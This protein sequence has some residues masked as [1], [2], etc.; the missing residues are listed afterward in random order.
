MECARGCPGTG[1][2]VRGRVLLEPELLGTERVLAG[3]GIADGG[4]RRG[5]SGWYRFCPGRELQDQRAPRFKAAGAAGL[6]QR[7]RALC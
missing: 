6:M 3:D 4:S 7:M 2:W 5:R 1:S